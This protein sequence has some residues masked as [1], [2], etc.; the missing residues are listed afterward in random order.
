ML[1]LEGSLFPDQ[2]TIR[3]PGMIVDVFATDQIDG[4]TPVSERG[5]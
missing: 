5:D 4:A 1:I 3:T 2:G